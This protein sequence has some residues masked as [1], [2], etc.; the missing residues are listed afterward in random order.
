MDNS[1]KQCKHF[2]ASKVLYS[3]NITACAVSSVARSD[4][5]MVEIFRPSQNQESRGVVAILMP[6]SEFKRPTPKSS[7]TIIEHLLSDEND[8]CA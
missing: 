1:S 3:A 2:Y 7:A 4:A 8:A 5:T 6:K